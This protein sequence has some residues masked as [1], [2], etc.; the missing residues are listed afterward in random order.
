MKFTDTSEKALQK[1]IVAHLTTQQ[2]YTE[3]LA[4]DFNREFCL[5]T[6]QLFAFIQATQPNAYA[7]IQRKGE[8]AFLSRLDTKL[9]QLGVV[10][11]LRKGIKHLDKTIHLFYRQPDT[12]LN[13]KEIQ[14]YQAN[15]LSVTQELLYSTNAQNKNRL[16][17][18]LFVNGIPVVTIELKNP[19]TGQTVQNAIRQYKTDRDS[20]DKLLTFG[21]C[22]VHFAA[23][24][25]LVYMCAQLKNGNSNFLPFNKGL[26][27]GGNLPPFGAGN[28]L[29]PN[30]LKTAYLWQEVLTKA[31][32]CNIIDKF[33]QIVTETNEETGKTTKKVIFP[34][35]HQL[36]SVRNI[37]AHAKQNGI[38]QRYL[39]QHSAGSGKSNSI[40]WLAHQL[41]SLHNP[42]GDKHIFDSVIVITDRTV[43]DKQLRDNIKAFNHQKGIVEAITGEG[44][45]KKD[46]LKTAINNRKKIIICTVQTFPH[47]LSEM[48]ELQSLN[49]GIIIDEAH[50]SQSGQTSAKM[51][52]ALAATP[53]TNEEDEE[54]EE[55]EAP[56]FEDEINRLIQSRKM[57]S[58]G[59]Y[60]A[61]TATPKNKTLETFG[62]PEK[63]IADGEE[64]TRFH[65][66]HH[67]SMKQA[68]EE[69]FILDVLQNYT[70]YTSFY[71]LIKAVEENPQYDTAQAQK[72][73]RSYVEGHEFAIAEKAKIIIDH[74]NREVQYL[75]KG[76]AKAMVVTKSILSAIKY[77][78]AFDE[79][80]KEINSPHKAIVAFSGKKE[81]KGIEYDENTL[82]Q[83]E[84]YK[85]DIPRNFNQ[86]QYKFLIVANKYQ[87]GFDQPLLHTMYVDKK[88]SD[89]QAV[90]T[91]SRL[92]RAYKPDK[93]DTFVLDFYNETEDIK[94][95]FDPYYTVTVL[96]E[97]TDPNKLNDLVD[98]LDHYEVYTEENVEEF[99]DK[100]ASNAQRK[101][102]DP[103]LDTSAHKFRYELSI[104]EQIAFKSKAKSFLRTYSYLAKLLDFNNHYWE[105]LWWFLKSLVPKL[106]IENTDDNA[107]GIL[108]AIDM[109]SYR[110]SKKG[111][112]KISLGEEQGF[113]NPIPV[114]VT[115][116]ISDADF[117]TLENILKVF[118]QRF[119][120]IDWT[121]QD[122]VNKILT[123]DIPADM[124]ADQKVLDTVINTTDK[125]NARISSDKKVDELMQKYLFTQTEIYKK[126]T[127]DPDFQRRYREFIFNVL[128]NKS[129]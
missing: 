50:S 13:P 7:T 22:M 113:V 126:Y 121:D 46:Q 127:S 9:T 16:D 12:S 66:F 99:F 53:Q 8:R 30:G 40:A 27:N 77:K 118:N 62:V 123:E 38:G 95:A 88:L 71:K 76:K 86:S 104:E 106:L 15:T 63:Y 43:L 29:N 96:S 72:K 52:A 89:V 90:Q 79:Y 65:P 2:G 37:L 81:Y 59:S 51:N 124:Q 109:D 35:Y 36:T 61:F 17:L 58:N 41:I 111:T 25:E 14:N 19:L 102:I 55:I 91:L 122:K 120:D 103:I 83:F 128:W 73:L 64:K 93:T 1:I 60:F 115:G 20:K 42:T 97:E 116:G 82:N 100:Y 44:S 18:T 74:F 80:L 108:E 6:A 23:D 48:E 3:T 78:F 45:S 47:L 114:E 24:S 21:R 5:N 87:T 39:V 68:I 98:G 84:N 10:E 85:N 105:K 125:Q 11:V 117:D 129:A 112:D 32:L 4:K 26:N 119:G 67:Y 33:A 75:I 110:P 69:G 94:A 57:I 49:F 92:N 31:S 34:R 70:T 54:E 101:I 56:T 107:E 28:P